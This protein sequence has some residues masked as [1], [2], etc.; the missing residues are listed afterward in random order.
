MRL[1]NTQ[2]LELQYFIGSKIPQYAILSHT[3]E[4]DEITFQEMSTKTPDTRRKKG[5]LKIE[6]T[7][8]LARRER[9]KY[10]WVD[11]CCI[12]KTSSSELTEA[13]NSMFQWFGVPTHSKLIGLRFYNELGIATPKYVMLSSPTFLPPRD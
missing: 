12:D 10:A 9:L 11:T 6:Q 13:I 2:T 3:W 5:Y 4:D 7:C 1:I 8:E